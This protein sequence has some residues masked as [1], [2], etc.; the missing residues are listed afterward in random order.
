MNP[1][2]ARNEIEPLLSALI[3]ELAAQGRTTE[4]AIYSGIR[5][6]LCSA[7]NP[8]ELTRPFHDLSA[9]AYMR[10]PSGN[11]A[12]CLLARILEKTERLSLAAN[13]SPEIH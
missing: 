7:R 5:D 12:D 3:R 1:V 2:I 13:P 8:C 10:R 9:M 6:R 11:D 4:R